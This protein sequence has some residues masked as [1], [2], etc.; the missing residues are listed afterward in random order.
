MNIT[1]WN[2]YHPS[3]KS[4]KI[5]RVY[6]KGIHHTLKSIFAKEENISVHIATQDEPENGLS[7]KVLENTDVLIWWGSAWQDNVLDSVAE[8]VYKR[9]LSGMGAIFLHSAH[10]SKPFIKLMGTTCSL[11]WR[12]EEEKERLWTI[13]PSHPIAYGIPETFSLDSEKMY[14]EFFDIPI[15]DDLIFL[16]WFPG[17]EVFRSGCTFRRGYGKIFYFQPGCEVYPTY[18]DDTIRKIIYN[19]AMW[20]AP[21]APPK[22]SDIIHQ[23]VAIEKTKKGIF[24]RK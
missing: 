18:Y 21:N 12:E 4:G 2:E 6:P 24:R 19:A 8:K 20:V 3:A 16:G 11:K 17:G 1:I 9:V 10:A 5:A 23:K 22:V 14:G 15:P 13:N 7:D